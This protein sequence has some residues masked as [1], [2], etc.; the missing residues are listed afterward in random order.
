MATEL[1]EVRVNVEGSHL[2]PAQSHAINETTV[3]LVRITL[4]LMLVFVAREGAGNSIRYEAV[5][6]D[7]INL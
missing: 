4:S 1:K 6:L 7:Y 5:A 3:Q 2:V